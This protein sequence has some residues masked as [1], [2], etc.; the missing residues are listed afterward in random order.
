MNDMPDMPSMLPPLGWHA[1]LDTWQAQPAWY[2]AAL[3]AVAG[4]LTGVVVC[5]RRG[6]RSVL[7]LRVL[8]FLAGWVVLVL[9]V[10]SAIDAYAM[11][12]SGTT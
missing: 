5:R 10:S 9:T 7:P 12:S 6:V 2:A 3:L 8:T 1:L 11:P 4:Y